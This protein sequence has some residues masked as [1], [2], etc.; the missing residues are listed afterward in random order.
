MESK[1]GGRHTFSLI[2]KFLLQPNVFL[3]NKSFTF[4][5]SLGFTCKPVKIVLA[6]IYYKPQVVP[7][8]WYAS[9]IG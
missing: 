3:S 4:L 7:Y 8:L 1:G 5:E 6:C 9:R 2:S